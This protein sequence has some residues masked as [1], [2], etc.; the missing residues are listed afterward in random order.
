MI[1]SPDDNQIYELNTNMIKVQNKN[2][3]KEN[4]IEN[5]LI[6]KKNKTKI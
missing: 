1:V 6:N 2:K 5:Y 4:F 3:F